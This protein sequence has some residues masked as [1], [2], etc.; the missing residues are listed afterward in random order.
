MKY[1]VLYRKYRPNDF[2]NIIGQDYIIKTLKNSIINN[3]ISHA[4]IFSGP[5]G[6]GKTTIAKIFAYTANC[7]EPVQGEACGKCKNCL[8][9]FSKECIDIIE[10]DAASNNGVDEIRELKSK[11]N[12]VPSELKYKIYIIDEVH[13]LSIGAFNALLKTLEE[14]P[15]HA[16]FI[17]ATTDPQ[18]VPI[19]I[20]SRC[21]C[22]QFKRI[23]DNS[24][25]MRLKN[26]T[27]QENLNV[28][29][30]VLK[31]IVTVSDGGLRDAIGL[32]DQVTSYKNDK[33]TIH[34]FNEIYGNL[35]EQDLEKMLGYIFSND[36]A[37][38]INFI[39]EKC[40]EGKNIIQIAKQLINVIKNK[41]VQFYI[42]NKKIE[43]DEDI[44]IELIN[45]L[46]ERMFD[47]KKADDSKTYVEIMLLN[48]MHSTIKSPKTTVSQDVPISQTIKSVEAQKQ[49]IIVNPHPKQEEQK[50]LENKKPE[51]PPV[52]EV[53]KVQEEETPPKVPTF[54]FQQVAENMLIKAHNVL[55]TASKSELLTI[56]ECWDKLADF[57]FDNH[58]GYI[59]CYLMDGKLCAA[60][61]TEMILSYEYDSMLE[62]IFPSLDAMSEN[63]KNITTLNKKIIAITDSN[64]AKLKQEFIECKQK[65]IPF[66]IIE[67]Q[68]EQQADTNIAP[69]VRVEQ[70]DKNEEEALSL[71]GDIVEFN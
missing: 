47:I 6:T 20:V 64:W 26:I 71:F 31:E 15:E 12:I 41:L 55:A 53:K 52:E 19:T 43:Y 7:L 49:E 24:M 51:E 63:F 13:M 25:F 62:K 22:F 18:K 36:A 14:P 44:C 16:I 30:E 37:N 27:E 9:S 29:E 34:D 1:K 2:D 70:L 48:F 3:N 42:E 58:I 39:E 61:E 33:V 57:T 50:E 4:Y 45:K 46:N 8:N 28:E 66:E 54:Y 59:V 38:L 60:N 69:S 11:V 56:K 10:I 32:L 35:L 68:Q 67:D 40:S 17:L 5:R 21:Q 23:D 65:G